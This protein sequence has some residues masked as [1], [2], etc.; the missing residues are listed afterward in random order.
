MTEATEKVKDLRFRI[1]AGEEVSQEELSA[2]L[3]IYREEREGSVKAAVQKK[4]KKAKAMASIPGDLGDLF[5]PKET[6]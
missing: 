6:K 5:K 2:A 3:T 1:L 4:E